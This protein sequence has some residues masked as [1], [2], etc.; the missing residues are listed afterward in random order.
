[1]HVTQAQ[2]PETGNA[3]SYLAHGSSAPQDLDNVHPNV[4]EK[5]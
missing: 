3:G 2:G 1:M 4:R 5:V